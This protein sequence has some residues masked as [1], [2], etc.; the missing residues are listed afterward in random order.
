MSSST[1]VGWRRYAVALASILAIVFGVSRLPEGAGGMVFFGVLISA[2]YGGL[3]PGVFATV[4][5]T[6]LF[7]LDASAKDQLGEPAKWLGSSVFAVLGVAISGLIEAMHAAR[8]AAEQN[9]ESARLHQEAL[10]VADRQKDEFLATLAHEL[11]NPLNAIG[12]AVQLLA[13]A[14]EATERTWAVDVIDRQARLLARLV[15]DLLDVS[16]ITRGKIQLRK[17]LMDLRPVL[18]RAIESVRLNIA[19]RSQELNVESAAGPLP[20]EADPARLEQVLVNLLMNATKYTEPGGRI[21]VAARHDGSEIV[22][23]ICDTGAGIAPEMLPRIFDM[24]SQVE[25]TR[26]LSQGGLGIGLSLVRRLVEMHG[27]CVTAASGG[28]GQGSEFVVR[29]PSVSPLRVDRGAR[30]EPDVQPGVAREPV[31]VEG[32]NDPPVGEN[33]QPRREHP[34]R[35]RA[36]NPHSGGNRV[37]A[38]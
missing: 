36:A 31:A 6:A 19:G 28:P 34:D 29:L 12:S 38:V 25:D 22:V 15:E 5:L 20:I 26:E 4:I 35:Q 37:E 3:G 14:D 8:R 17:E 23:S 9:A 32:A 33:T 16:R 27:G 2:W 7:L 18:D 30:S 1:R 21:T 24:F 11:R 13:T 10:R